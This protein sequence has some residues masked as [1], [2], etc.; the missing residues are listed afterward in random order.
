MIYFILPCKCNCFK[1]KI[2]SKEK[3]QDDYK[4]KVLDFVADYQR[5]NPVTS[6]QGWKEWLANVE[7]N[8]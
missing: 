4:D 5:C 1:R 6:R 3:S 2:H 7:G 8:I